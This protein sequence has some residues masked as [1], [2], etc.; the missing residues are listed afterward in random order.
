LQC[1]QKRPKAS[2]STTLE[3][4]AGPSLRSYN[5]DA[6]KCLLHSIHVLSQNA[7]QHMRGLVINEKGALAKSKG[8][9]YEK[10][11]A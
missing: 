4:W 8:P 1:V 9:L 10:P 7:S 11:Y 2:K 5:H 6:H 3:K